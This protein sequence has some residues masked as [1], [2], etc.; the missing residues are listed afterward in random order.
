M[1]ERRDRQRRLNRGRLG[2]SK[3]NGNRGII[4]GRR[5]ATQLPL[6]IHP[7]A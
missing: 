2:R 5:Q 3:S 7:V 4:A 1:P 6:H